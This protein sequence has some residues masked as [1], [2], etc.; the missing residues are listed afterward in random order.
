GFRRDLSLDRYVDGRVV[1]A[2]QRA[3]LGHAQTPALGVGAAVDHAHRKVAGPLRSRLHPD[4]VAIRR[5]IRAVRNF[6]RPHAGG[7]DDTRRGDRFRRG[8]VRIDR[9][10]SGAD[11]RRHSAGGCDCDHDDGGDRRMLVADRLGTR[12][13]AAARARA[14]DHLGDARLQRFDDPQPRRV[15]R[16]GSGRRQLRIRNYLHCCGRRN[17]AP[18]FRLIA[19]QWSTC[20]LKKSA[21][22]FRAVRVHALIAMAG[23]FAL[24]VFEPCAAGAATMRFKI[25]VDR[26]TVSVSVA[27]P[28]AFIR[29][30]A[31]GTLR[32]IDGAVSGDPANIPGT[33]SARILIDA[34]SY[35]SDNASR[36][37]AVTEKS[38]EANKFPTIG[39]ESKSVVGVVMTGGHE[40]IAIVSGFL[41]IHGQT[42]TMTMSV[43]ATLDA[44]G[45]FTG[46]GEVKFNYEEFGVKVPGVL[47]GA[48][49]AGDEA[50]V[51]FHI[52]AVSAE[53]PAAGASPAAATAPSP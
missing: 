12:L 31:I 41:T 20:K 6:A 29:G 5:R 45:V 47:F 19:R 38:L 44:D 51:R 42:Q 18:A 36:D 40:G 24:I 21:N 11:A 48:I 35:R 50:T 1:G 37:R 17:R 46:D 26:S 8:G 52:V 53:T 33:A 3:R 28:A 22:E 25:D 16:A 14:A 34:T 23:A 10:R 27:E 49:L 32:I 43:H 2:D 39:F 4:G 7:A 13:D 30:H 9:C 15:E